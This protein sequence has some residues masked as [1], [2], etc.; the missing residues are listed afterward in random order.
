MASAASTNNNV[1]PSAYAGCI[2]A[3]IIT[4]IGVLTL[5]LP[6]L[7]S[8]RISYDVSMVGKHGLERVIAHPAW[9][10]TDW[11]VWTNERVPWEWFGMDPATADLKVTALGWVQVGQEWVRNNGEDY[12][13]RLVADDILGGRVN[14]TEVAK[15]LQPVVAYFAKNDTGGAGPDTLTQVYTWFA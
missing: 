14:D 4:V 8:G 5:T 15:L 7:L 3:T 9:V 10:E 1:D 2:A 6:V 11:A 13:V 12:I